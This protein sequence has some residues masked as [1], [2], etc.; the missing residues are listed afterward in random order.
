MAGGLDEIK[1]EMG[2]WGVKLQE[3][4]VKADL[5]RMEVR[6]LVNKAETRF[7]TVRDGVANAADKG[8]AQ[9]DSAVAGVKAAWTS[10]KEA[11]QAAIEKHRN[12]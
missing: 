9:A 3:L 10:F 8:A 2:T 12:S 5:S 6:D 7:R 11:Y 1:K 4:R